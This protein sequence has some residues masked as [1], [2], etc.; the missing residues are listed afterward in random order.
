MLRPHSRMNLEL[1]TQ[2]TLLICLMPESL[3]CRLA[4]AVAAHAAG[5]QPDT[6]WK[7]TIQLA[8]ILL[9]LFVSELLSAG[10]VGRQ[11]AGTQSGEIRVD[12]QGTP[13]F[14]C[15]L[16]MSEH[17]PAGAVARQSAGAQPHAP[18]GPVELHRDARGGDAVPGAA[19]GGAVG[20]AALCRAQHAVGAGAAAGAAGRRRRHAPLAQPAPGGVVDNICSICCAKQAVSRRVESSQTPSCR[21]IEALLTA[22]FAAAMPRLRSL[23]LKMNGSLHL[24][25]CASSI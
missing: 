4:G 3:P 8:F 1:S 9:R 23:L 18:G 13:G 10:A 12:Q 15:V 7:A 19:A 2:P 16:L 21:F 11:T 17:M 24:V 22:A 14:C 6:L 20:A 25:G 5:A